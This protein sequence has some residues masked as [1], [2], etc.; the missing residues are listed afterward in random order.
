M[1]KPLLI[2]MINRL[3]DTFPKY[4]LG[5]PATAPSEV[6]LL[7]RLPQA[8]AL[9]GAGAEHLEHPSS[10]RGSAS[11]PQGLTRLLMHS[12]SNTGQTSIEDMMLD[13]DADQR[14]L[15]KLIVDGVSSLPHPFR[16]RISLCSARWTTTR[17]LQR[18]FASCLFASCLLPVSIAKAQ[19]ARLGAQACPTLS[20]CA[21]PTHAC[22]V[23]HSICKTAFALQECD[24]LVTDVLYYTF[25][26][27]WASGPQ[28][29]QRTWS[30]PHSLKCGPTAVCVRNPQPPP[31]CHG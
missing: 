26:G 17:C 18:A 21:W 9:G 11:Q 29:V 12:T 8:L 10:H 6:Q 22:L 1:R 30:T 31:L 20:F 23:Y 14:R 3:P 24:A 15:T 16:P 4:A 2:W 13:A 7:C 28:R 27:G 25:A 19:T 5:G